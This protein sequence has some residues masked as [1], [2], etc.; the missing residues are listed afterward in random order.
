MALSANNT[1]IPISQSSPDGTLPAAISASMDCLKANIDR[2]IGDQDWKT[3]DTLHD[4]L[5]VLESAL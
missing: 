2:A 1:P 5:I 3:A 4:A